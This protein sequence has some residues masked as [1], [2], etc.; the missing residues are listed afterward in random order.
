MFESRCEFSVPI[1]FSHFANLQ[2]VSFVL[3]TRSHD[4]NHYRSS[5]Q[6]L[7]S[8]SLTADTK[9]STSSSVL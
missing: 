9:R 6:H 5:K 2:K 1:K 7:I 4:E 3:Q 8:V